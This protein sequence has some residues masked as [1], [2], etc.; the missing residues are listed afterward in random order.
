[1]AW[2]SKRKIPLRMTNTN[3]QICLGENCPVKMT[4]RKHLRWLMADDD[5][6]DNIIGLP[7]EKCDEYEAVEYYGN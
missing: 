4:C 5:E 3:N 1:M 7:G 6:E 2:N